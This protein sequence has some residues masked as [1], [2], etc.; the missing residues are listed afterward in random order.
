MNAYSDD[1]Q[2]P[3]QS[4]LSASARQIMFDNFASGKNYNQ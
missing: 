2:E 1:L 4:S 3:Y